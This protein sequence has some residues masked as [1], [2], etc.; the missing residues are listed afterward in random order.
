MKVGTATVTIT[1]GEYGNFVGTKT[2]TFKIVPAHDSP[3]D[4]TKPT[5]KPSADKSSKTSSAIKPSSTSSASKLP[6]TSDSTQP[7][8]PM[9]AAG[10]IALAL[11]T[12]RRRTAER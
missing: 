2:A 5:K 12:L 1:C 3:D 7:V 4:D 6:G 9:A 11:A 8:V 10:A